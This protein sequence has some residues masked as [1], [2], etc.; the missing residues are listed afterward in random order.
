[1]SCSSS[2][3]QPALAWEGLTQQRRQRD[4]R[5]ETR[6]KHRDAIIRDDEMQHPTDGDEDEEDVEP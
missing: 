5:D 2:A 4:D 6:D 3:S 1:M